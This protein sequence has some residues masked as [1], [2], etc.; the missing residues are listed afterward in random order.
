MRAD[1]EFKA[2]CMALSLNRTLAYYNKSILCQN[3]ELTK[4]YRGIT[5]CQIPFRHPP[6]PNYLDFNN[7][8]IYIYVKRKT[9]DNFNIINSLIT[10]HFTAFF[11]FNSLFET[12]IILLYFKI[13]FYIYLK[14]VYNYN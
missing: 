7:K 6:K 10:K 8:E 4:C 9:I 14:K 13:S 2:F 3:L 5:N 12:Q 11:R 1:Y